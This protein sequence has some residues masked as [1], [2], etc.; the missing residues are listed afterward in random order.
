MTIHERRAQWIAEIIHDLNTFADR[1]R[2]GSV[3]VTFHEGEPVRIDT[4]TRG[5]KA[6]NII[7]GGENDGRKRTE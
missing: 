3:T 1:D 6:L 2:F 7:E 5:R 4:S